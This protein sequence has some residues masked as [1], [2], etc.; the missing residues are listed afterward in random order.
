MTWSLNWDVRRERGRRPYDFVQTAGE[1]LE[2][3]LSPEVRRIP[4]G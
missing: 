4:E 2:E 3:V 1:V